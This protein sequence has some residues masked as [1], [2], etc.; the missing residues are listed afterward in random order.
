MKFLYKG[1]RFE[2]CFHRKHKE[3]T[4]QV[5]GPVTS[6]KPY[7]TCEVN[8]LNEDGTFRSIYR[9]A[10]VGCWKRDTFS[11]EKGRL[12]TLRVISK[13]KSL[14]KDFKKAMWGA[15]MGRLPWT[16]KCG[17]KNT[18]TGAKGCENCG[19]VKK[20]KKSQ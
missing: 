18:V 10:T 6:T 11:P 2:I 4:S 9:T 3:L 16:C 1:N 15:Y 5:D 7:T 14:S 13:E 17:F 8:L 12:G 20:S 19:V